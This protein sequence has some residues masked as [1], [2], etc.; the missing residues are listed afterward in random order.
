M[1][2]TARPSGTD[3]ARSIGRWVLIGA[4]VLAVLAAATGLYLLNYAS[5]QI[6]REEIPALEQEVSPDADGDGQ[7]DVDTSGLEVLVVGTDSRE[8]LTAEQLAELGTHDEGTN[9]TD[10]VMLVQVHPGREKAVVVSFPR[11]LKVE[12]PGFG[13]RK[14][15]AVHGLGGPNLL[16][17]VVEDY[18]GVQID[19]YAE[20]DLAGFLDVVDAIGGVEVCLQQQMVD[21]YAGVNLPAGCQQL[22]SAQSAGFV[23]SRRVADE[24]GPADDFGRI[25]RQQYFVKQV[26][27]QLTNR[28]TLL[29]PFRLRSLIDAVADAVVVDDSLG[30][31]QLLDLATSLKDLD[32]EKVDFRVVPGFW[33]EQTGYVHA[34]P[35]ETAALMQA[36][37]RGEVLP[38]ELGQEPTEDLAPGDVTVMVLNGEG[39]AGLASKVAARLE[40][41]GFVVGGTDNHDRFDVEVTRILTTPA[42]EPRARLLLELLPDAV[43]EVVPRLEFT[44]VHAVLV[45]GAD[46]AGVPEDG[47]D[48]T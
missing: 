18:T 9:L 8:R 30:P 35:E 11:D 25:A 48:A 6:V 13:D 10:T 33:S 45:V 3:R 7:P 23:R 26:A 37:Q 2:G 14:I 47:Q 44:N 22:N 15:N 41:A 46:R 1:F 40:A 4:V 39:T 36:L 17:E 34:Y 38:G 20:I 27:R 43:L 29:N 19:H 16:V 24:F 12:V 42:D 32:P 21:A 31:R 5:G 28:G